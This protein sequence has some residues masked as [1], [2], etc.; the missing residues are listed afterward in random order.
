MATLFSSPIGP[1]PTFDL[2]EEP[3]SP[4]CYA[5]D[6][7]PADFDKSFG[8][9]MSISDSFDGLTSQPFP[10]LNL[11]SQPFFFGGSLGSL[12]L[13]QSLSTANQQHLSLFQSTEPSKQQQQQP[14][15][16]SPRSANTLGAAM[17]TTLNACS[18]GLAAKMSSPK[19]MDISP[20]PA[21]SNITHIRPS[22]SE[23]LPKLLD[24]IHVGQPAHAGS[25]N[26]QLHPVLGGS[27]RPR[28]A[29][30]ERKS[31]LQLG[32]SMSSRL[33]GAE[34]ALNSQRIFA[35]DHELLSSPDKEPPPKRRPNSLPTRQSE[36]MNA[37]RSFPQL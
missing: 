24:S 29:A 15:S 18:P 26:D 1:A 19:D 23:S 5:Q 9:S 8:S 35:R 17:G 27:S 32:Q 25:S 14:S 10:T 30:A 36:A 28:P 33:F 16:L 20:A 22:P 12:G 11:P 13:A 3:T 7:L 21:A 31:S 4:K 6:D 34:I 2:F 37:S